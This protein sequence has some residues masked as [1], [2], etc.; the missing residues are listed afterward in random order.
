MSAPSSG[1]RPAALDDS[2]LDDLRRLE[3]RVGTPLVAYESAS[4]YADLSDDQVA[5]I[6]RAESALGV[7]LLAYR[8]R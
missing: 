3:E 7:R 2:A 6:Q 4:P 1:L 5:E 8:Q